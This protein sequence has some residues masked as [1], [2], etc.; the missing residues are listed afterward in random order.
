M[1]NSTNVEVHVE[2]VTGLV[3]FT[4]TED[5]LREMDRR[6]IHPNQILCRA[7]QCGEAE[8]IA[9][10]I[11]RGANPS[12]ESRSGVPALIWA[13]AS[14]DHV[15]VAELVRTG[16]NFDAIYDGALGFDVWSDVENQ[17]ITLQGTPRVLWKRLQGYAL[18][19]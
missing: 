3:G 6:P 16:A 17:Y 11:Q 14:G 10:L 9:E 2:Y 8:L 13:V 4:N 19:L 15:A 5:I 7:A 18:P 12:L 1:K